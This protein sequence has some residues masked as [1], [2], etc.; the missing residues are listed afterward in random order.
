[1]LLAIVALDE[2]TLDT[3]V[4]ATANDW[5]MEGDSCGMGPDGKYTVRD[6]L[7]GLLVVSGNDCANAL[8]RLLGGYDEALA[9]MNRK[10]AELGATDT[11]AASPSGL[12]APG[13]S[14][15]PYDLAVLF[16]TAMQNQTFRQMISMKTYLFPGY[17][18]RHDVPGDVDHPAWM[19]GTS[20]TL[21]RDDWPG[22]LGGKTGYTDDAL[23]TFVG[24]AERNGRTVVIVQMYGLNEADNLYSAQAAKMFEY[25]FAA[26]ET[27][28]VGTLGTGHVATA[29][30]GTDRTPTGRDHSS[31]RSRW[32]VGLLAAAG[33][34]TAL[35]ALL[36]RRR[37]RR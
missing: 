6:M 9:K 27:V 30:D 7:S 22:M 33:G 19:M 24:A 13:M 37:R 36:W 28:S 18:R 5:S 23:K 12:D 32:T 1:M 11:R 21:L 17:P 10:A 4:E 14:T 20:N 8:A 25:G 16:R 34:C 31:T 35:A 26:P 2:L 15:S 29:T 3:A